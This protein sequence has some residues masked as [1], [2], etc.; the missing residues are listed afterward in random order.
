M[1]GPKDTERKS[2]SSQTYG[3]R[4]YVTGNAPNSVR[5]IANLTELC[6]RHLPGRHR[7]E[8]ID[9]LREPRRALADRIM[10][11]PTLVKSSPGEE[12]RIVGSLSDH[13]V[14]LL[15]LGLKQS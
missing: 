12:V 13:A 14:I 10:I 5:A 11:T 7:I 15:S 8:V 2:S 9:L 4:L 6:E 1:S 3:F